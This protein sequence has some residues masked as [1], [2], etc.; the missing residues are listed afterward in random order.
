MDILISCPVGLDGTAALA[1]KYRDRLSERYAD[2]YIRRA[3]S[4]CSRETALPEGCDHTETGAD[5][6]FGA[7]WRMAEQYGGGFRIDLRSIP[8]RQETIEFCNMLDLDPYRLDSGACRILLSQS[9][10]EMLSVLREQ[11]LEEAAVVG[12]TTTDHKKI[13]YYD[14]IERHLTPP[15]RG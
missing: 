3:E 6:I 13:L 11:G 9:G 5:G 4:F 8:I 15:E 10:T 12:Y 1:E 14:G 7:L 2:A